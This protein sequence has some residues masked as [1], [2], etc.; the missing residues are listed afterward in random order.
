MKYLYRGVNVD[1]YQK[2]DGKLIPKKPNKTFC[3]AVYMGAPHAYMGSEVTMG[4]ST[5]NTAIL[6]QLEQKG[7]PTSGLSF[8]P[9]F[10]RA[11]FYATREGECRGYVYKIDVSK[12]EQF[13]VSIISVNENIVSPAIPEDDEHIL[14]AKDFGEIPVG[15]VTDLISV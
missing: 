14:I 15:L 5:I 7:H 6:H 11:K 12:L 13:E 9:H 3:D 4:E 2:F 10:E 1:F 8:T